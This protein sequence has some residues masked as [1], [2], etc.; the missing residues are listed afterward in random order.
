MNPPNAFFKKN[1][2]ILLLFIQQ[3]T[4]L[5]L[6]YKQ[7]EIATA[8]LLGIGISWHFKK[9]KSLQKIANTLCAC[10][11]FQTLWNGAPPEIIPLL[12][13]G[14]QRLKLPGWEYILFST[15][16][17]QAEIHS[18][19]LQTGTESIR[20]TLCNLLGLLLIGKDAAL[21]CTGMLASTVV[22]S[23]YKFD[24]EA[25]KNHVAYMGSIAL[26][27]SLLGKTRAHKTLSIILCTLL[28]TNPSGMGKLAA[29]ILILCH[30]KNQ[31]FPNLSPKTKILALTSIG[32]LGTL[33][34]FYITKKSITLTG[35]I[36]LWQH[37]IAWFPEN[38]IWGFGNT[39]WKEVAGNSLHN[40]ILFGPNH[41]HNLFFQTLLSHGI[42]G[43]TL[44]AG[45]ILY[46]TL[47]CKK[48]HW[49]IL[50]L[51]LLI[52]ATTEIL[53]PRTLSIWIILASSTFPKSHVCSIFSKFQSLLST[54][55]HEPTTK[56]QS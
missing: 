31:F 4:F 54:P 39:F 26:G 42:V 51:C 1:L 53:N 8:I 50:L 27:G 28:L 17:L 3:I 41:A 48:T 45:T 52:P 15:Y 11:L 35:R 37:G 56:I 21:A 32:T 49:E 44:L 30:L 47:Q 24:L 43:L 20:Y 14:S 7:E 29:T 12:W 36:P 46:C 38:P 22:Y 2:P 10:L 5:L 55:Q 23:F 9:R 33:S 19:I 18:L 40:E 13:I 6:F 25:L 34:I 16:L